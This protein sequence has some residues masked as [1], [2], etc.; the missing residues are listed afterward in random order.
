MGRTTVVLDEDLVSEAMR[1]CGAHTKK[2]AIEAGLR[3]LI[4]Q[5]QKQAL[6]RELGTFDLEMTVSDLEELRSDC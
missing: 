1:A 5:W 2:E 4:R 6:I 3:A